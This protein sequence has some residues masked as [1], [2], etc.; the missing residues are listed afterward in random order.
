MGFF[1]GLGGALTSIGSAIALPFVGPT[2]LAMGGDILG[3]VGQNATN[4]MNRD[5][6]TNANNASLEAVDRNIALQK[7]FAQNGITWRIADAAR[8]GISPLAALGASE[9]GFS[10]VMPTF[11]TPNVESPLKGFGYG[12]KETGQNLSRA[13]YATQSPTQRASDALDLVRKSKEN[14]LLDQQV[15]L[16]QINVAKAS[17]SP[18]IPGGLAYRYVQNRDGTVSVIPSED[19]ARSAH[20]E[21]F[22]PLLWSL[23]NGLIPE[24]QNAAR[25]QWVNPDVRGDRMLDV[26]RGYRNRP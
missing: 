13:L 21:S 6:A 5:I 23:H 3:A 10:P 11:N 4:Q 20:A 17:Q 26:D 19:A 15:K 25:V 2:A 22:G 14:D 7:E 16:A 1:S 12:M 8:N 24:A 9:P 18:G